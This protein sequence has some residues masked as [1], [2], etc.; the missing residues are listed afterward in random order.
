MLLDSRL[1]M[2]E[3]QQ[4]ALEADHAPHG[5]PVCNRTS[6]A[7]LLHHTHFVST[8]CHLLKQPFWAAANITQSQVI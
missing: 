7:Y 6:P 2:S 5:L 3:D 8:Y 4:R 1:N